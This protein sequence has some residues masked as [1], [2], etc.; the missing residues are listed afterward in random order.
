MKIVL[1]GCDGTGKTTLAK[2]KL[3]EY[4]AAGYELSDSE[5]EIFDKW[6]DILTYIHDNCSDEYNSDY[7]YGLYQI[8]EEINVRIQQGVDSKGNPKMIQKYGDLNDY[9]KELKNLVKQYY[10]ENLVDTLF[11]YEFLK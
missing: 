5:R 3:D 10:L 1:E 9:I 2:E 8:D 7:T 6:N 11:E 4:I